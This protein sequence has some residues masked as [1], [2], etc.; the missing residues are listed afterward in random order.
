MW[1]AAHQENTLKGLA[2]LPLLVKKGERV[3][4]RRWF[5]WMKAARFHL[6]SWRGLLLVHLATAMH[7]GLYKTALQTPGFAGA[8]T[9]IG[10]V[11]EETAA[12]GGG[13]VGRGCR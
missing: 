2:A 13:C 10:P 3:M 8:A 7:L 9:R 1:T 6:K 4:M 11:A 5:S 12:W